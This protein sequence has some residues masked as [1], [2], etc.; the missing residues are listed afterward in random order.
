[1]V[2]TGTMFA[3]QKKIDDDYVSIVKKLPESRAINPE[4]SDTMQK[5]KLKLVNQVKF[6]MVLN[7]IF[8]N[9]HVIFYAL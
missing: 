3:E 4:N 6:A 8:L 5:L 7:R 9:V 1:M 2:L